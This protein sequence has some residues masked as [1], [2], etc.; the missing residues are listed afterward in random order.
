MIDQGGRLPQSAR[1]KEF[2]LQFLLGSRCTNFSKTDRRR[3]A[4]L[5]CHRTNPGEAVGITLARILKEQPAKR[6]G[7]STE[8]CGTLKVFVSGWISIWGLTR[9]G[10]LVCDAMDGWLACGNP[11]DATGALYGLIER[12]HTEDLKPA[13][14]QYRLWYPE[15]RHRL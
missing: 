13:Q 5:L 11:I 1:P 15:L 4:I 10:S 3:Q 12:Q 6:L 2:A 8:P 14:A 9:M 7:R